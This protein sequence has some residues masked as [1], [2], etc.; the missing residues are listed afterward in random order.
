MI[1]QIPHM[2][3][4]FL[5]C[6][7]DAVA[8]SLV[9]DKRYLEATQKGSVPPL[10]P[11]RTFRKRN[12]SKIPRPAERARPWNYATGG[13]RPQLKP[14]GQVDERALALIDIAS[15]CQEQQRL[16]PRRFAAIGHEPVPRAAR[17]AGVEERGLGH[18]I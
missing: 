16:G 18:G 5:P 2:K 7:S 11:R 4:V 12:G 10:L 1:P 15:Q 13:P 3:S 8:G 14:T 6:S 9:P 17:P